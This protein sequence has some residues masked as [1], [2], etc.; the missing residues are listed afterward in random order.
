MPTSYTA[1]FVLSFEGQFAQFYFQ[2]PITLPI[3]IIEASTVAPS[4]VS[5]NVVPGNIQL[6]L[7]VKCSQIGYLF[8]EAFL[9]RYGDANATTQAGI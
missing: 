8:Y 5:S 2:T 9:T 7:Y 3:R 1:N 6:S 4:V